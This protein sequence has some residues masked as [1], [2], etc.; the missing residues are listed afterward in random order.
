MGMT[1]SVRS[2]DAFF[3]TVRSSSHSLTASRYRR[4]Q[5]HELQELGM[6]FLIMKMKLKSY[7]QLE[8]GLIELSYKLLTA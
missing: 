5:V 6:T 7:K 2:S 1:R 8:L 3:V 4:V